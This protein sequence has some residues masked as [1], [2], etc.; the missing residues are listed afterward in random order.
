VERD[1]TLHEGHFRVVER[2]E[3]RV[4]EVTGRDMVDIEDGHELAARAGQ[5]RVDVPRLGVLV[6]IARQIANPEA[7]RELRKAR[8]A[9][10]VEQIGD[11]RV[12]IA[13][14]ARRLAPRA[15]AARRT[16]V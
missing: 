9:R 4:E 6:I 16:P 8:I 5:S 15:R 11:V 12:R 7:G 3:G 10:V 13:S 2:T 14:V 1:A